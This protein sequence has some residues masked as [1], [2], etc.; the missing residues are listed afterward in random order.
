MNAEQIPLGSEQ[1]ITH[2]VPELTLG[3]RLVRGRDLR[4]ME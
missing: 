2:S 1:L 3:H 4:R